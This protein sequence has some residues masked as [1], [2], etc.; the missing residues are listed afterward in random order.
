MP[1]QITLP[2]ADLGVRAA[3]S[4]AF[5]R[6]GIPRLVELAAGLDVDLP[7]VAAGYERLAARP[8]LAPCRPS[9]PHTEVW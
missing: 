8:V 9:R 6:G 5:R 7:S 3:I 4:Q 1:Q 2:A